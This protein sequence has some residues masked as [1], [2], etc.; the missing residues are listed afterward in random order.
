MVVAQ[1]QP[2]FSI[3]EYLV[4][5]R[6]KGHM[7]LLNQLQ[8]RIVSIASVRIVT[9]VNAPHFKYS[10]RCWRGFSSSQK[11]KR[12]GLLPTSFQCSIRLKVAMDLTSLTTE[13]HLS[14]LERRIVLQDA[15][16]L[17]SREVRKPYVN[18]EYRRF[19]SFKLNSNIFCVR[20]RCG[21]STLFLLWDD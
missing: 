19:S 20:W 16:N 1:Q 3:R 6:S 18:I 14:L 5:K 12:K 21:G 10:W 7:I 15:L 9:W 4:L 2:G 11:K 13:Q 8:G 17:P